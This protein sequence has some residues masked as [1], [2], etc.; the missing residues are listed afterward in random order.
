MN[1]KREGIVFSII[2]FSDKTQSNSY[3]PNILIGGDFNIDDD[4][5]LTLFIR[6]VYKSLSMVSSL[7]TLGNRLVTLAA[8][9][10]MLLV[11][12]VMSYASG[13]N[14]LSLFLTV[15]KNDDMFL[16][17]SFKYFINANEFTVETVTHC[18]GM[19]NLPRVLSVK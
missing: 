13:E 15:F 5:K 16:R 18:L 6:S 1:I 19:W 12:V 8:D 4:S 2:E 10:I 7:E 17:N 3:V 11:L 9:N 14:R